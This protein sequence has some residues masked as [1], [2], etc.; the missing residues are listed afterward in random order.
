MLVSMGSQTRMTRLTTGL[1]ADL[2]VSMNSGTDKFTVSC[3]EEL[4]Y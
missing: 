4:V 3:L 1:L 2:P